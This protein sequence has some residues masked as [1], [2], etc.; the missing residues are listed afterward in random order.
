MGYVIQVAIGLGSFIAFLIKKFF[1]AFIKKFGMGV[2][3]SAIQKVASS[4]VIL[5]TVTFYGAV[6]VFISE[7]YTQLKFIIE[8]INSPSTSNKISSMSG[9]SGNL[10]QCFLNLLHVSGIANGFNSAFSFFMSVLLF[11]LMRGLYKITRDSLV[12]VS[13]EIAKNLKLI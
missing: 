12:I 11:F 2:V 10:I 13:D 3:K 5:M 1:P 9:E 6:I 7:T 8:I 4:A